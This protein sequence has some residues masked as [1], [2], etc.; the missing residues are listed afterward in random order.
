MGLKL[1]E[2]TKFPWGNTFRIILS[3]KVKS[4]TFGLLWS[5]R[6]GEG[7]G[8]LDLL[9]DRKSNRQAYMDGLWNFEHP[10]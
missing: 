9:L 10:H 1:G 3:L 2:R 5:V 4:D 8:T 6:T 7:G